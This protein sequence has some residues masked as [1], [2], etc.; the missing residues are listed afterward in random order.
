MLAQNVRHLDIDDKSSTQSQADNKVAW[1]RI[2][3]ER[4]D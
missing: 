4:G 2:V 1:T 3:L